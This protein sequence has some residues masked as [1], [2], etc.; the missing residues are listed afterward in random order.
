MYMIAAIHSRSFLK[1]GR[2]T[3]DWQEL[4]QAP[5]ATPWVPPNIQLDTF[6]TAS[7]QPQKTSNQGSAFFRVGLLRYPGIN[8][9]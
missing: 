5:M 7:T 9:Y 8:E 6:F 3:E 1:L 4:G 2:A